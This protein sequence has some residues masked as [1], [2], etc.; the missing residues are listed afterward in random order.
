VTPAENKILLLI[1]LVGVSLV[2]AVLLK[3]GLK[4]IG[5]PA[6]VGYILFGLIVHSVDLKF[7]L[8]SAG[9]DEVLE[10]LA[11]IGVIS[12]LFRVGLESQWDE[13]LRQLRPASLV[14]LGDV[15]VSG[16]LGFFTAYE[17][18]KFELIPSLFIATAMTAT[19]VGISVVVWQEANRTRSFNGEVMLD[20][21]E[22][23]DISAVILMALLFT[24]A[25]TLRNHPEISVL[26]PILGKS[27]GT[28]FLKA[29]VFGAFCFIFSRYFE[30]SITHFFKDLKPPAESI[31]VVAGM[32]FIIAALAGLLGFSVAI[33]A[34]FGGLVFSRDPDSVKLDGLFD[35]FYEIFVPFF[36]IGIGLKIE[37]SALF[38]A[39][40]LGIIFL[41]VAVVG[42][43]IGVGAP[44]LMIRPNPQSAILLGISM[45]P[46]AEITMIVMQQGLQMG[47][48]A[49]SSQLFAAMVVV[50]VGTSIIAPLVLRPLL[51]R[52]E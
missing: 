33:G 27:I 7:N 51:Q 44:M 32:S 42:K 28:F 21:A 26:L 25:P 29:I 13:L 41:G 39:W 50:S 4:R 49:V 1:A 10:F 12:L 31:I 14:W 46:R 34:F 19:S 23:D 2:I 22:M 5:V 3:A 52:W 35:T 37:I 47:N 40:N 11:E 38:N 6:L 20:V 17:L 15:L 43:F 30:Q 48:W 45:I 36:F 8:F 9:E 18:L 24:V 16:G